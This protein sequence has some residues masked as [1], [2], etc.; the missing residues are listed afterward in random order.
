MHAPRTVLNEGHLYE[1]RQR[2]QQQ[3]V[4]SIRHPE[5]GLRRSPAPQGQLQERTSSDDRLSSSKLDHDTSHGVGGEQLYIVT[6]LFKIK[7]TVV[8]EHSE[9]FLGQRHD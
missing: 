4:Y 1:S 2:N 7:E 8:V 3:R 9:L 6:R 5:T